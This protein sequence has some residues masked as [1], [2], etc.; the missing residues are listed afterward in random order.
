MIA[1]IPSLMKAAQALPELLLRSPKE[2][3]SLK[4]KQGKTEHS[5][6]LT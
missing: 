2:I 1:Q 6:F 3:P 5:I 4:P